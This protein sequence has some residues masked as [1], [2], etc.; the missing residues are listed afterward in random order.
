MSFNEKFQSL[1]EF[2]NIDSPDEV[3]SQ[4]R[5]NENI[6]ILLEEV[7][8]YLEEFFSEAKYT[9]EMNFEPELDDKFIILRVDVSEDRFNNGI[10]DEIRL[11]DS[12]LWNLE[13]ELDVVR[14]VLI[15]P[16]ISDV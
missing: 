14:E 11:L 3:R 8:P 16:G 6:F 13:K 1:G 15:M 2:Y 10:G 5:N 9:L 7:K 12:K 4:I